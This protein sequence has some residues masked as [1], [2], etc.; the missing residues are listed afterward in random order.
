M[1][2]FCNQACNPLSNRHS[3]S[4]IHKRSQFAIAKI[5]QNL[6]F[7]TF[8]AY[9]TLLRDLVIDSWGIRLKVSC[10]THTMSSPYKLWGLDNL[11][12][13]AVSGT[14]QTFSFRVR[15]ARDFP[16]D[17]YLLMDLSFS[18]EDDLSNLKAL[19]ADLGE[20]NIMKFNHVH[21]VFTSCV[22]FYQSK[23]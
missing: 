17:I 16:I 19:G 5:V 14:P 21:L 10:G 4:S 20:Q 3:Q 7:L 23:L 15:P 8:S 9:R 2:F 1:S 6:C 13:F 12:I 18:M 11:I 22:V